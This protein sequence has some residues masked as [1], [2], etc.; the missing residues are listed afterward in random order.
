VKL[1]SGSLG[2]AYDALGEY[3]RAIDFHQQSLKIKREI[4]DRHGEAN[5]LGNLG[6]AYCSLGNYQ[7]AIDFQQQSL[8]I[9]AKSVIAK[10][11]PMPSAIWALRV[12]V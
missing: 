10:A 12:V 8:A 11:K 7:R 4:G 9:S 6:A 2:N 1:P 3:Q 5:S